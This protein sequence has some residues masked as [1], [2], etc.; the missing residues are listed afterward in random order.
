MAGKANRSEGAGL[1]VER[2]WKVVGGRVGGDIDV[3]GEIEGRESCEGIG[4]GV[5]CKCECCV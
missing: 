1:W 5:A 4:R 2:G 3:C